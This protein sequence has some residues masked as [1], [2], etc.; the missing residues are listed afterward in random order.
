LRFKTRLVEA[1]THSDPVGQ[2]HLKTGARV[3]FGREFFIQEQTFD[4]N[5]LYIFGGQSH[6]SSSRL[7]SRNAFMALAIA[8]RCAA[9]FATAGASRLMFAAYFSSHTSHLDL[10]VPKCM[11]FFHRSPH[12]AM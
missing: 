11:P 7:L 5:G 10:R 8:S 6:H 9:R 3:A 2:D 12:M 1:H 4:Q